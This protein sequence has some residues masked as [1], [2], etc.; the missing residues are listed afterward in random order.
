M[1]EIFTLVKNGQRDYN[2]NRK[3][4]IGMK[5]GLVLEGG[6]CRGVFTSGVL[7]VMQER[8]LRFDYCIG[9]SA[10]AGNAMCF[11]SRQPGRAF[12]LTAG[13]DC[14]SSFGV[15]QARNSKKMVDLDH[16]YHTMSYE[17]PCPFDFSAYHNDP[18]EC[19]Y[20][21]SC[22]ETGE[23][24]YLR[25]EVYQRRLQE[26]A[27]ASSSLPGFCPPVA[28]DGKHYLDGGICDALPVG[29]AFDRGCDKV[30]LVTTKPAAALHP[31]DYRKW[32]MLLRKLYKQRFPAM[33]DALMNRVPQYFTSLRHILEMEQSG[34][35]LVI[36]PQ[37]C[38]INMLE[39]DKEKMAEY[40]R[41]GRETAEAMWQQIEE[42]L[43]KL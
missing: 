25:E 24:E 4:G 9:V 19:E 29:R 16:L 10:G 43:G 36:R 33:Y 6:A 18:M 5:T 14:P 35:I 40:Y 26:I 41:H 8:D 20:V 42:Y 39:K 34:K 12:R 32:R 31:T 2:R 37:V 15:Q 17:G 22:C 7:D 27:K 23:A 30:I 1:P 3:G 21:V 11:K 28:L 38:N 13:I